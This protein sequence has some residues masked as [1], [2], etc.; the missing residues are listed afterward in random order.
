[1]ATSDVT[2]F[3]YT[4]GG[5]QNE[6]VA[7]MRN[8]LG[9]KGCTLAALAGLQI[10]VPPGF[11]VTTEA[12]SL[13]LKEGKTLRE[14]VKQQARDALRWLEGNR[15]RKLGDVENPLILSVRSGA[16]VS[17]PGMM[18][19]VLNLGLNDET[20]E[21][22]AKATD[23]P[24]FAYDSYRRFIMMFSD[25]VL[26]VDKDLFEHEIEKLKEATGKKLDT[27]I[28]TEEWKGLTGI[29]KAIVLI[30][31]GKPFPQDPIEQLFGCISAVFNK[32][33]TDRA[34][35][36]RQK[37]SIPEE[38]GTAAYIQAMVF[39][40]MGEDSGTGVTFTRDPGTGE[41][42]LY[43]EFL[44]NAQG[45][46]IVAGVRSPQPVTMAQAA[47]NGQISL[48]EAMPEAFA[49]LGA[50]CRRLEAHYKDMQDLE[51]TI[52]K[53]SLFV[54]QTRV[55]KRTFQASLRMAVDMVNEGLLGKRT[56]LDRLGEIE[57]KNSRRKLMSIETEDLAAVEMIGFGVP[58][59]PGIASGFAWFEVNPGGAPLPEEPD[60]IMF[61]VSLEREN[62]Q[63]AEACSALV[64]SGGGKG[65]HALVYANGSGKPCV[66]YM[67]ITFDPS[68]EFISIGKQNL[69]IMDE[70]TVDGNTGRLYRGRLRIAVKRSDEH[71][72]ILKWKVEINQGQGA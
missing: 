17:M 59:S 54:L 45:E 2:K 33:G 16:R 28:T 71:E 46:D 34:T 36:Y 32:W 15:G 64:T 57:D 1:M 44:F 60:M 52:E 58:S 67:P 43:G 35:L 50:T 18:D 40:N 70:V 68:G 69:K 22:L 24:R 9:G 10:P 3:V 19:T 51:F 42:R 38:W 72:T 14:D 66:Q 6:G 30:K 13:Y 25:V 53:G 62:S 31:L 61:A 5:D 37:N 20:V 11:T 27:E 56:A 7:T 21:G 63:A 55:G 4:F 39:G 47:G 8:L 65:S 12:C 49:A 29:F 26:G 41:P 23:N 48:E